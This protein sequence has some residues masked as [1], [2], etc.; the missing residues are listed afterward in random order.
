[1]KSIIDIVMC[2]PSGTINQLHPDRNNINNDPLGVVGIQANLITKKFHIKL[3][4]QFTNEKYVNVVNFLKSIK[5]KIHP[6]FMGI[7][8]NNRGKDI[9]E[10]FKIKYNLP[11][12][13]INTSSHLTSKSRDKG[14]SMDK[15]F[16]IEWFAVQKQKHNILFSDNPSKHMSLLMD[17]IPQIGTMRTASGLTT[18]KAVR[19]RHDDLFLALLLCCHIALLYQKRYE[20][21]K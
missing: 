5:K 3:A 1:M 13:G 11:L 7:E 8:T 17:Q 9:Q 18:Y 16:M 6:D 4:R 2:D 21:L 10:L 15:A 12:T 19:G 20:Q 14:L